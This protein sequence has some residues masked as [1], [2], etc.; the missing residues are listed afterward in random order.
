MCLGY[1]HGVN[2]YTGPF[3]QCKV[4]LNTICSEMK[5]TPR[6]EVC[7]LLATG[8]GQELCLTIYIELRYIICSCVSACSFKYKSGSNHVN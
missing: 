2:L 7:C 1:L 8:I 4:T 6:V 5:S 3:Y